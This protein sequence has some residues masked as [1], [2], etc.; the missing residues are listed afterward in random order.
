M[1]TKVPNPLDPAQLL[2]KPLE[3]LSPKNDLQLQSIFPEDSAVTKAEKAVGNAAQGDI[4]MATPPESPLKKRK[5]DHETLAV[6]KFESR[7]KV[8]GIALV[9]PE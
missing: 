8:K 3:V 5:L 7:D 6:P 9:K 4:E 1:D 2:K